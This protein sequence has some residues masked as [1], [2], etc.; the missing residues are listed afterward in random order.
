MREPDESETKYI[1]RRLLE[2]KDGEELKAIVA[3]L[4]QEGIDPKS[5]A[6]RKSE[7][8]DKLFKERSL[9]KGGEVAARGLMSPEALVEL[10][11]KPDGVNGAFI[12]GMKYEAMNM[13]RGIRMAQELSKMGISQA[14][15][16]IKMAQEMRKAEGQAAE[17]MA[18]EVAG[19]VSQGNA[20]VSN[21]IE[22]LRQM[23]GA[24]SQDPFTRMI[25]MMQSMQQFMQMFGMPMPGMM[26]MPMPGGAPPGAMPG[27]PPPQPQPPWQPP[28]IERHNISELEEEEDV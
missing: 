24:Q 18:S 23:M 25:S 11:P 26:G 12:S 15:P 19:V 27:Q 5:I 28:P 4:E 2:A 17:A 21:S 9:V 3:E 14:D 13:I 7:L 10:M 8:K 22:Q 1:T 20:R 6:N 16:I